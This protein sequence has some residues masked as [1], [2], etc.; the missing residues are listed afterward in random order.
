[1]SIDA[2]PEKR[3]TIITPISI[4]YKYLLVFMEILLCLSGS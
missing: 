4:K 1:V 3:K 2:H